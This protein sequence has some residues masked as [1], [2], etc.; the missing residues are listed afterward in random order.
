MR[1]LRQS[2]TGLFLLSVALGLLTYAGY[3]VYAAVEERVTR[4]PEVPDRREREFA[5]NV[6][7]AKIATITPV[8]TAFGEV[9]SRRSLE[10]RAKSNGTL[11]ELDDNFEEGARVAVG[12]LLAQV[13]P[14]DAQS[15]LG[16]AESDLLDAKAEGRDAGKSLALAQDELA[17][18]GEQAQ[19]RERAFTRQKDLEERG[20]GTAATTEAAELSAAQARQAVLARRLAVAA[21]EARVDQAVTRESRS[22]I[23]LA[24]AQRRLDETRI[25]AEFSGSLS[26][27]T[28]VKGG[29]VSTNER[30]AVLVDAARLEVAFRV[31]TPQFARL[32]DE[33]G[34]LLKAPVT[35]TLEAFGVDLTATGKVNRASAAVGEGQTGR[36]VFARLS[37]AQGLKP[38][39]FVTVSI[40]EPPLDDVIRLPASALGADGSVLVIDDEDRLDAVSVMLLRRQG[41]DVLLRGNGLAGREVVTQRSPLLG[42]GIKVRP[43]RKT[44]DAAADSNQ[45]LE[46]TDDRRARLVA[47]VEGNDE[48]P[49][50]V[51]TRLLGE[52]EQERVSARVVKRL[53]TRMGG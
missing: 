49:E 14:A 38:G 1:F 15:A 5:V 53:E 6:T 26:D 17:A 43:I 30:L 19:L 29:L 10:I 52:L 28:V 46:L 51:K 36:L 47:F 50:A 40:D 7:A 45:M 12:Q 34:A 16:R 8:L 39:D 22:E 44:D 32:L 3:M 11:V 41:D 23:A 20:V 31:S 9:Q 18:A 27:V 24:E 42:A 48:M 33:S 2:L 21:A 35:A 13:D 4:E 37:K 25:V